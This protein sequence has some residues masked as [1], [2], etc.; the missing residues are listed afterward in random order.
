MSLLIKPPECQDPGLRPTYLPPLGLWSIRENALDEVKVYDAH[1]KGYGEELSSLID[2]A[3]EV[4]ISCQLQ[5]QE[6]AIEKLIRMAKGSHITL[7]GPYAL[8]V[9]AP[10]RVTRWTYPGEWWANGA[11][12]NFSQVRPPRFTMEEITPYWDAKAPFDHARTDRWMT[13]ETSRGCV[14]HCGFCG[15]ADYWDSWQPR[16]AGLLNEYLSWL[17]DE[18]GVKELFVID[19][20]IALKPE[21]FA[22]I[23][24][25][26]HEHGLLWSAPNGIYIKALLDR[27]VLTTLEGSS[28]WRLSLPFETTNPHTAESMCLGR[29]WIDPT[30]ASYVVDRLTAMGIETAGFFIIGWPGETADDVKRTLDFANHLPL[31]DRYIYFAM[32]YRGTKLFDMCIDNE[33]IMEEASSFRRPVISTPWLSADDLYRLWHEDH[34]EALRRKS[35]G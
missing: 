16:P 2:E 5:S 28:C 20:N 19:D 15:M 26:F 11:L 34:V 29:K 4:G 22:S 12:E 35:N 23:V 31:T 7:G 21:R 27:G 9:R 17:V 24:S 18:I 1:L 32:P 33:W 8:H 25:M 3:E 6:F 14:N 13:I 30:N 10:S